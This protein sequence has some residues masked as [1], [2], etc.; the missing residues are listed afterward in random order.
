MKIVKNESLVS[1]I[2][3]NYNKSKFILDSINSC[4]NQNYNKKEI[5]F[6]DDKSSDGSLNKIK[7][8]KKQN[9]EN[10]RILTNF[11][12]TKNSGPI[13]QILAIKKSLKLARGKYVFLLDADD[14]FHKNKIRE[15][16]NSFNK[17]KKRKV[18][19]DQPIYKYK[20]KEFKKKYY[21]V[22]VKNKWPKFPPTSCMCFEK[23]TLENVI[24][25]IEYKKFP[26]LGVDFRL[27]VYYSLI[28]KN[29]YI[30]NSHLT[31]YR[32]V[33]GSMDSK[34][35]KYRSKQWWSR[36]KEAFEFL[37]NILSKNKLPTN[38]GLD[39]FVTK[40]FNNILKI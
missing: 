5:I 36:R 39:F 23:K 11:K 22:K 13:N 33:E 19:L 12:K 17:N 26:N 21:N 16:T 40:F 18:I 38:K 7:F 14:F 10:F 25:K 27:A 24:E 30:L 20:T 1:I 34:Y 3:T 2:I 8:F 32:Q 28:L 31:Y 6:F 15:I 9:G 35:I 37:N 4:L 29:F